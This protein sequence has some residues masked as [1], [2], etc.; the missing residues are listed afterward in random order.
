MRVLVSGSRSISD[1]ALVE[2]A[3][4]ESGFPITTLLSGGARGVDRMAEAWAERHGIPI[5]RI[6]PD[7][8]RHGRGAG[9]KANEALIS[10]AEAVVAIWDGVSKGT[11]SVLELAK[12]SKLYLYLSRNYHCNHSLKNDPQLYGESP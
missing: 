7:W 12:S 3:I 11:K 1:P 8:K 4:T 10:R 5:E 6:K 2:Q 9:F